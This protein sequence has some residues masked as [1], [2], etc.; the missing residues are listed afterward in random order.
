MTG[1]K[2]FR[3]ELFEGLCETGVFW[4]LRGLTWGEFHAYQYLATNTTYIAK[5]HKDIV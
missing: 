1:E 4:L 3:L 5:K 2:V